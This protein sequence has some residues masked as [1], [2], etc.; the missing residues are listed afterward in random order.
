MTANIGQGANVGGAVNGPDV[1]TVTNSTVTNN[2]ASAT[3][4]ASAGIVV[5][6]GLNLNSRQWPTMS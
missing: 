1:L 3:S 5:V 4:N 2:S 6:N